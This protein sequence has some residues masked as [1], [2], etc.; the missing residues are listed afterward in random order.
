MA[1]D[2]PSDKPTLRRAALARRADAPDALRE[3]FAE[4]LALEGVALARRFFA[5]TVAL[6]WPVGTEPDTLL[7]AMACDY[8]EIIVGLPCAGAP[9]TPL[10]FR[11]WRRGQPTV[12][13]VMRIPEPARS[14]PE[15][16]PDLIFTPLTAFDRRGYRLGYGGGYYDATLARIR[17]ARPVPTVGVGFSCQEIARVPEQDHDQPLDFILTET[18]LIDCSLAWRADAQT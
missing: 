3:A 17:A 7:L 4:R 14:L 12:E 10:V 11:R 8:H 18:E 9:G 15:V 5:R 13:G 6:F 2:A 16:Q 1:D